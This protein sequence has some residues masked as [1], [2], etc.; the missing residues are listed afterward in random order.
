MREPVNEAFRSVRRDWRFAAIAALLL[1]TTLG[2]ATAMFSA[3][4]AVLL[5]PLGLAHQDRLVV[6]WKQDLRRA[7]PIIEVAYGEAIDWHT[8]SRSFDDLAVFGS[9]NWTLTVTEK[10]ESLSMSAVS[11]NFFNVVGV[12]ALR[13]RTLG[14]SDEVGRHPGAAVISY[15]LWTQRFARDPDILRRTLTATDP[16]APPTLISI[17][18]VMPP[19]FDF[20]RHVDVWLPAAPLFRRGPPTR[21]TSAPFVGWVFSMRSAGCAMVCRSTTRL[22]K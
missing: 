14:P 7:L 6:V 3:V 17:V 5:R 9:V 8:R 22:E 21:W 10:P 13:G 16:A 4:Q 19:E 11:S 12:G 15:D 20:P 2:A 1:A 18:G